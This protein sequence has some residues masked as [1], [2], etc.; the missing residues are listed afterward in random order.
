MS[1]SRLGRMTSS[2][3]K[4]RI[5]V[6]PARKLCSRQRSRSIALKAAGGLHCLGEIVDALIKERAHHSAPHLAFGLVDRLDNVRIGCASAEI[7]AHMLADL[8]VVA[9]APLIDA[10][11][12]RDD[13]PRCAIAALKGVLI[14]ERLLHRMKRAARFA[15]PLDRGDRAA[16]RD[17]E[18]QAAEHP[19][20][21][22]QHCTGSALAMIAAL[23][24]TGQSEMLAQR[25][26]QRCALVDCQ[27]SAAA[28]DR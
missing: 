17:S 24:C 13:L 25:I 14:D 9:D 12:R 6:P 10:A 15:E 18:G 23:F 26:E 28:I 3:I 16:N 7:A 2:F 20:A 4:S 27:M 19:G 5:V 8:G 22:N 11:D 1:T 21:V